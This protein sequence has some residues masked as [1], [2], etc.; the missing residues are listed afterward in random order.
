MRN[1]W[2]FNSPDIVRFFSLLS[3]RSKAPAPTNCTLS[4][5]VRF[6]MPEQL[7]NAPSPI[8][9]SWLPGAKRSVLIAVQ[10]LKAY[11]P[12]SVTVLGMETE[13]SVVLSA[14]LPQLSS[15]AKAYCAMPVIVTPSICAGMSTSRTELS[16]PVMTPVSAL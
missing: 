5:I 4:G 12:I 13:V 1:D 7:E 6:I 15:R 16:E 10:W 14:A 11:F 2:G 3:P 9:R 8:V